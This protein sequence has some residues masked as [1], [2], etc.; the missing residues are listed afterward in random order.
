MISSAVSTTSCS[1]CW[2]RQGSGVALFTA[3]AYPGGVY[4]ETLGPFKSEPDSPCRNTLYGY[5]VHKLVPTGGTQVE[6]VI[7]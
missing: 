5:M 3:T 4:L 1:Q 6:R 2:P 7:R